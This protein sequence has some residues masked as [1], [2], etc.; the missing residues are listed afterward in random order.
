MQHFFFF[1]FRKRMGEKEKPRTKKKELGEGW[2]KKNKKVSWTQTKRNLGR[3]MAKRALIIFF[4]FCSAG[5]E[6]KKQ[7]FFTATTKRG[8]GE[9]LA[10]EQL[11]FFP[12]VSRLFFRV[13]FWTLLLVCVQMVFEKHFRYPSF[14]FILDSRSWRTFSFF[15]WPRSSQGFENSSKF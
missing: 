15:I 2:R 3:V 12:L 6:K 8:L 11:Y 9:R 1:F 14:V 5:Q 10:N 13:L 4:S 7:K